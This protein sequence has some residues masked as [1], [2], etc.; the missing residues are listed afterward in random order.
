MFNQ[1]ASTK[2]IQS[3][4]LCQFDYNSS[5]FYKRKLFKCNMHTAIY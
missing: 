4:P 2:A 1:N 5:T 3:S